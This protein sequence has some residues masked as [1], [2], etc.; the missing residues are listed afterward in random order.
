[1]TTESLPILL[2]GF[3]FGIQFGSFITLVSYR[4]PR[5]EDIVF[6]P[7]H[8]PTCN[9]RL[10]IVDLFPIFSWLFAGGKCRHCKAPVSVRY[11][12]IEIATGCAGVALVYSHP[13]GTADF[14]VRAFALIVLA[15]SLTMRLEERRIPPLYYLI[16]HVAALYGLYETVSV[17]V[18]VNYGVAVCA[19]YLV[20]PRLGAR[21]PGLRLYAPLAAT[22]PLIW[23]AASELGGGVLYGYIAAGVLSL[24]SLP[25]RQCLRPAEIAASVF[26]FLYLLVP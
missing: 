21:F 1:M 10:T 19:A 17:L 16:Y 5:G 3:V 18:A 14:F 7:S 24:V 26:L 2:A 25:F 8:C 9:A 20:V 15:A 12:L 22:L 13:F 6:T 23:L 11:P 4:V